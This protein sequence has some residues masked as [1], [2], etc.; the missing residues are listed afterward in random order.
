M[1][2]VELSPSECYLCYCG[3]EK[4]W[5][6]KENLH[7]LPLADLS[8]VNRID[9]TLELVFSEQPSD[10]AASLEIGFQSLTKTD[11][12]FSA[13]KQMQ[14]ECMRRDPLLVCV[15]VCVIVFVV[16]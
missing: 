2:H 12:W 3:E 5:L 10:A 4:Q 11:E 13:L 16:K 15:C 6:L 9:N 8:D 1:L 7:K 14:R